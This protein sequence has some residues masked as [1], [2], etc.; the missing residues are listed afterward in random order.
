VS[1]GDDAFEDVGVF[2][3]ILAH[4]EKRGADSALFEDIEELRGVC[5]VWTVVKGHGD[6]FALDRARGERDFAAVCGCF[7]CGRL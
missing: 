2:R 7:P 1:L 3:C 6:L 5:F 4:N